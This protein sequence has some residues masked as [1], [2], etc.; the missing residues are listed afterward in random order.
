MRKYPEFVEYVLII[1]GAFVMGFAI[2]N[3]YDPI[4]LVTGGVTGIAIVMKSVAGIPLWLTNTLCNIPLF[5]AAW[6]IKGWGFIKRTL[7]AT[8]A[9]SISLLVMPEMAFLTDDL[10]LTSLFGGIVCGAG[11]GLIFLFQ[12]TTGGTD[13]LAALIQRKLRHYSIA[14]IMQVLDGMVVLL[15]AMVFGIRYALYALIA[16]YAT[17]K[18]SDGILEGLK[19]SKQAYIISDRYQEIARAIMTRMDR[20]VTALDGVGMYSGQD[21]KVLFC[22]VSKKEIVTIREI[23]AEFDKKAFLI[24]TDVREVFGEGFI[25]Y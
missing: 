13:M 4:S 10:F 9:L 5:L 22:V 20:G 25:E 23:A 2:K 24:V 7:T 18:V 8:A 15:G 12:A 6:K 1:L 14:Q 16:I 21:K 17:A 3:L 19:F 11:T